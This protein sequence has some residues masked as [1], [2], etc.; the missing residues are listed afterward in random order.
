MPDK[1]SL[2]SWSSVVVGCAGELKILSSIA[3]VGGQVLFSRSGYVCVCVCVCARAHACVHVCGRKHICVC[4]RFAPYRFCN[5]C[6]VRDEGDVIIT[7]EGEI[8]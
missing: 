3:Q 2:S 5:G 7:V 1:I 4:A 6:I 8:W